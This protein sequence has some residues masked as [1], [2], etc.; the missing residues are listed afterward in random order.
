[1]VVG[2]MVVVVVSGLVKME[3]PDSSTAV[4]STAASV[5]ASKTTFFSGL[6]DFTAEPSLLYVLPEV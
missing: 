6:L 2:G 1:V 3:H 5:E 4:T